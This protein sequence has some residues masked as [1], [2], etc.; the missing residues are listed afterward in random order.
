MNDSSSPAPGPRPIPAGLEYQQV[1]AATRPAWWRGLVAI[2]LIV[3]GLFAFTI[4]LQIL[5]AVLNTSLGLVDPSAP[6]TFTPLTHLSS[7]VGVVLLIP[8]SMLV[9]RWLFGVRAASLHSVT[10]RFR[11]AVFGKA[12]VFVLP[13]YALLTGF[14]TLSGGPTTTW[15]VPSLVAALVISVLF[16][17]L[18]GGAE[19]YGFRGVIF[20][21]A[22]SWGAGPRSQ[23]VVG[24]AVSAVVFAAIHGSTDI[25]LNTYYVIFAASM[26]VI[27][28]RTGGLETAVVIHGVNNTLT[29]MFMIAQH[30]DFFGT[31]RSAGTGSLIMLAPSALAAGIATV[32]WIRTRRSGPALTP[33]T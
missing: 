21:A 23:L 9:Q 24:I 25:W 15:A 17:P 30:A 1:V 11:F 22:A 19:E 2:F 3:A 31:D 5:G 26:A 28:W 7:L 4:P 16:G 6:P 27:T 8:W 32:V 14:M 12:I 33:A 20:R 29:F 10:S 13:L 18:Q